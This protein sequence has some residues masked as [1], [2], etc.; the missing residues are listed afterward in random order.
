MFMKVFLSRRTSRSPRNLHNVG[1]S[2][3]FLLSFTPL[4]TLALF[5]RLAPS[6]YYSQKSL[7][8][9][10]L[11]TCR[12]NSRWNWFTF[13]FKLT[14]NLSRNTSLS[15]FPKCHEFEAHLLWYLFVLGMNL[16]Y[17]FQCEQHKQSHPKGTNDNWI[18]DMVESIYLPSVFF[19]LFLSIYLSIFFLYFFVS[20]SFLLFI[21]PYQ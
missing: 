12:L 7:W 4:A 20:H 17:T 11:I 21:S 18:D 2:G 13:L 8:V 16:N 9:E 19:S 15:A 5:E 6:Q 14:T 1:S 3:G 10:R